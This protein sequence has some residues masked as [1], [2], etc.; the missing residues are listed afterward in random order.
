MIYGCAK[1]KTVL[2]SHPKRISEALNKSS[3]YLEFGNCSNH[4][5]AFIYNK[6][7][8]VEEIY[9]EQ[10]LLDNR[11]LNGINK[12]A[13][14]YFITGGNK[15][16]STGQ[17]PARKKYTKTLIDKDFKEQWDKVKTTALEQIATE[18]KIPVSEIDLRDPETSKLF[19]E[20][21]LAIKTDE[22]IDKE[23]QAKMVKF[24]DSLPS[25]FNDE[26]LAAWITENITGIP[27]LLLR[28]LWIY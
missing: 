6:D 21:F 1:D 4:G 15:E 11:E 17:N 10:I 19:Q 8:Y 5:D 12:Q 18:K 2:V 16:A 26:A 28:L 23:E 24:I 25:D 14:D 20:K 9:N 22:L 27:A 13:R 7:K 3:K